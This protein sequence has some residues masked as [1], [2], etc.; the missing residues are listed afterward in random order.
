MYVLLIFNSIPINVLYHLCVLH[1]LYA[2]VNVLYYVLMGLLDFW[3]LNIFLFCS[4]QV[5]MYPN[6]C[7]ELNYVQEAMRQTI[8][9]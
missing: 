8:C 6:I 2:I 9:N 7:L 1:C 4:V 5:K 3:N